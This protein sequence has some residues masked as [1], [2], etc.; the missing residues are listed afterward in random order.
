MAIERTKLI[1]PFGISTLSGIVVGVVVLLAINASLL[2]VPEAPPPSPLRTA[3]VAGGQPSAPGERDYKPL[4]ERNLFR[5][6]LQ[7][8]I[9]KPKTEKEI[10]E[11]MLTATVKAMAL[12]G[13]MMGN[14]RKDTY[15][16]IDLGGQKGVWTY[17]KG[18]VV[19]KGLAVKEIWKDSVKLEKGEF[20]AVLK[21]FSPVYERTQGT[22][23][24]S[25]TVQQQRGEKVRGGTVNIDKEVK[26]I[27][28]E[29]G[30]TLIP[31]SLAEKLK[32]NNNIVMSSVAVKAAGDGL[33]VVAVDR[34]SIAQ[35]MGISPD[36][37]LQEINGHRLDSSADMNKMYEAL[38]D[39]TRFEMKVMRR[40]KSETLRYEIR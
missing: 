16:V 26:E 4:M 23:I 2:R 37:I 39:A 19:D 9:P 14:G 38:K 24:A 1:L 25:S 7:I 17:E 34:G 22:L 3:Q 29:G 10:E 27:R 31:K 40:G 11:E 21:L 30:V 35:K 28:K 13:V 8:E 18:E 12:K 33:K 6:K 36:D 32:V 5:A 20:G 15:A